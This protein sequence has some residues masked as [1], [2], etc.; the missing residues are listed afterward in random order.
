MLFMLAV[1]LGSPSA[2]ADEGPQIVTGPNIDGVSQVGQTLT[3]TATYTG[4]PTPT[5]SWKWLRCTGTGAATCTAIPDATQ[6]SHMLTAADL[7]YRIRVRL[8]VVNSVGADH[9]RSGVT[10]V[11]RPTPTPTPTPTATAT[12]TPTPVLPSPTSSTGAPPAL[13]W[14]RLPPTTSAGAVLGTQ[15]APRLLRPFPVVRMRGRVTRK[16][17]VVTLLTI[18]APRGVR[19]AIR[20]G[21]RGCPVRRWARAAAVTHARVFERVL[22]TGLRL[23]VR[24]S[25]PGWIGKYTTLLIRRSRPPSRVDRCLYPGS[26]RPRPCPA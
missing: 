2:R 19:I 12:P 11:I 13:P 10:D 8:S 1:C 25:R 6:S 15:A 20:C 24:V 23:T 22:P 16:G 7:A 9:K 4:T 26:T 18:R 14:D 5:A 3:A 21:G 17:A